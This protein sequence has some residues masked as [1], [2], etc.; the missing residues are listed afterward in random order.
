[1]EA[2]FVE[3]LFNSDLTFSRIIERPESAIVILPLT[4]S[5]D[6]SLRDVVEFV[7]CLYGLFEFLILLVN[8]LHL[9][10]HVV[11]MIRNGLVLFI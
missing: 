8:S 6:V 5:S 4:T 7:D 10:Q 2:Q 1:V 9:V 11:F 3:I